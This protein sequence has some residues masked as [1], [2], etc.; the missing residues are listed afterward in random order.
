VNDER[1]AVRLVCNALAD[2]P[3]CTDAV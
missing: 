3:D 2:A 1:G